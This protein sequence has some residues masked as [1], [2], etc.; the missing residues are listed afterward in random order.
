VRFLKYKN[1]VNKR[2]KVELEAELNRIRSFEIANIRMEEQEKSN[3]KLRDL[4]EE[5]E[6]NY[7]AKMEK[8]REREAEVIQRVTSKM[9][10]VETYNYQAR[11][12]LLK[13][14]ETIK[15]RE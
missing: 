8:L 14:I 7:R 4:E 9:K 15:A 2:F 1:E 6:I 12:R 3:L 10:E 5:L 11:Q 13:D